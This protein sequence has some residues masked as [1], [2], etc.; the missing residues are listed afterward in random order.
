MKGSIHSLWLP[1]PLVCQ[2]HFWLT[3]VYFIPQWRRVVSSVSRPPGPPSYRCCPAGWRSRPS[4][5]PERPPCWGS[6][7]TGESILPW[8]WPW[9]RPGQ[10]PGPPDELPAGGPGGHPSPASSPGPTAPPPLHWS[11]ALS[12]RGWLPW[13][14]SGDLTELTVTDSDVNIL[15]LYVLGPWSCHN[16]TT[17]D[18]WAVLLWHRPWHQNI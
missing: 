10:H 18:L 1:L 7:P 5:T 3:D 9:G 16:D 6:E 4:R 2:S 15:N 12:G 8:W 17:K 13:D 11:S 14:Q